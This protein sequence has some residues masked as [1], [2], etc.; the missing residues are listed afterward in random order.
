MRRAFTSR[1]AVVSADARVAAVTDSTRVRVVSPN[2][3]PL[4]DVATRRPRSDW[5]ASRMRMR[6]TS[7]DAR[8]RVAMY[9]GRYISDPTTMGPNT[10]ANTDQRVRTRSMYSRCTTAHNFRITTLAS[11]RAIRAALFFACAAREGVA[12]LRERSAPGRRDRPRNLRY[13]LK[14]SSGAGC[15]DPA[16][17]SHRVSRS[18]TRSTTA[19]T[20]PSL[21]RISTRTRTGM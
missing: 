14:D 7:C 9:A 17:R 5:V 3:P 15:T 13:G 16:P 8:L 20:A 6:E 2:S 1:V 18:A 21:G 10:V 12:L 11:G 4:S 19:G